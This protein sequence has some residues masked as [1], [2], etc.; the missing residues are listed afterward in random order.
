MAPPGLPRSPYASAARTSAT[1]VDPSLGCIPTGF[2]G[3]RG[4][5]AAGQEVSE[6]VRTIVVMSGIIDLIEWRRAREDAAAA[7]APAGDAAAIA[8]N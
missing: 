4:C 2:Y 7:S 6:G 3:A 1:T 8:R 5:I